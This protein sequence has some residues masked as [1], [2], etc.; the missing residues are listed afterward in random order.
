MTPTFNLRLAVT[1]D[2]PALHGLIERSVRGL[3]AG[4][5][6]QQ[7]IDGALGHALG[8]DTQLIADGTYFVA[9]PAAEPGVL[10]G[11]GGWSFRPRCLVATGLEATGGHIE[12]VRGS[13]HQRMRRRFVPSLSIRASRGRA[14]AV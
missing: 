5:Y 2:V 3:Q 6:T 7:Q 11:C 10:A 9:T 13:I 8:L 12:W 4:D 1:E 14:W